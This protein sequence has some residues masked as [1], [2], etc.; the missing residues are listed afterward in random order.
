[1]ATRLGSRGSIR[2]RCFSA[3]PNP[4]KRVRD[5]YRYRKLSTGPEVQQANRDLATL[6]ISE[7]AAIIGPGQ[8]ADVEKALV[9]H[10]RVV[11]ITS[12]PVA[13]GLGVFLFGKG[14]NL[15]VEQSVA[16]GVGDKHGI[17]LF[18]QG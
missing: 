14:T 3:I 2:I 15:D 5:P 12:E 10:D 17:L 7:S 1:M 9:L 11:P 18:A 16:G 4:A 13:H 8:P 6:E